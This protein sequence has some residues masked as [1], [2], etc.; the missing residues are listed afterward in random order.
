MIII[1]IICL[2]FVV[3][4]LLLK[5]ERRSM[6]LDFRVM[7]WHISTKKFVCLLFVM[8]IIYYHKIMLFGLKSCLLNRFELMKMLLST[9]EFYTI[10][11]ILFLFWTAW[12]ILTINVLWMNFHEIYKYLR[13]KFLRERMNLPKNVVEKICFS[14]T[15]LMHI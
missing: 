5:E 12:Y 6:Y 14:I 11:D 15:F 8:S 13:N 7:I 9:K 1:I 4:K 10:V 2:I 3:F